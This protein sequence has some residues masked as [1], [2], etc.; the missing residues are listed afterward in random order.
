M[1]E[2]EKI[3]LAI[4]SNDVTT[5]FSCIIS[6]I[7]LLAIANRL[8]PWLRSRWLGELDRIGPSI[9]IILGVLGTFI[10]IFIGLLDFD[11]ENL[12]NSVP[13]LLDGLKIAFATSVVGILFSI[14]LRLFQTVK[15]PPI[16]REKLEV[17]PVQIHEILKSIEES[18]KNA[19][20]REL[21]AIVNL[22]NSISADNDS[23]L[24]SQLKM[25][26]TDIKDGQKELNTEFKKFAKNITKN[27]INALIEALGE[28]MRDFNTQINEQFGDN[29]KELN[30]AV[31]ALLKWQDKYKEHVEEVEKKIELIIEATQ[32]SEITLSEI[33]KHVERLPVSLAALESI[34]ER[35][36]KESETLLELMTSIGE[37]RNNAMQAFPIIEENLHKLTSNLSKT[38]EEITS[39]FKAGIVAQN[40]SLDALRRS[41]DSVLDVSEKM[42]YKTA[43]DLNSNF[44]KFDNEMTQEMEKCL[45]KMGQS[46]V[47][48]TEK[49]VDDYQK[50][51][52]SLTKLNEQIQKQASK[53]N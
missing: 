18:I 22:Q 20:E 21:Q 33:V 45:L 44:Q 46:L 17:T 50:M 51:I 36:A 38:I 8:I 2:I 39:E 49:F 26:R 29:F 32:L 28:V 4:L 42:V 16:R 31:G 5:L 15:S 34:Y 27:N 14:L 25:L 43:E 30:N 24:N 53:I 10:G 19:S 11:V 40:Q 52:I 48:I 3:Y 41:Q 37:L 13:Q 7:F 12:E 9:L 6:I 23:S 35:S 1:Q 47:S